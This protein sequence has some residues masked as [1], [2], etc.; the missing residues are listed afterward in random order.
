MFIYIT[1]I[2]IVALSVFIM[3]IIAI[4]SH[5]Y[6]MHGPGWFLHESHHTKR[7]NFFEL[8]DLFFIVFSLPSILTI[9][10]G[11]FNDSSI[12]LCIGI[13]IGIYGFIYIFLHDIV[14]HNRLN[15]KISFNNSY[16]KKIKKAH[17]IHHSIKVKD[18]ASH[19]GFIIYK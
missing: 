14:V 6:I 4:L 2:A 17:A 13:G 15:L 16:F 3:E 10:Y 1:Y 7:K 9:G 18:G 5:K 11:M 8:N 19:F 12:A